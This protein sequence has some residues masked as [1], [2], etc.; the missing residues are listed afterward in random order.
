M[1]VHFF[2]EDSVLEINTIKE[3]KKRGPI[4]PVEGVMV[5]TAATGMRY[6]GRQDLAIFVINPGSN[7]SCF[8]TKNKFAAA[9]IEI[10]K[11]NRKSV[12]LFI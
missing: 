1:V 8:F 11:K 7:T 3:E 6:R 4:F 9:P 10:S 5:G 12:R 2:E